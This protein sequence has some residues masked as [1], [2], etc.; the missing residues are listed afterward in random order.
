MG[1][2]L[3][4]SSRRRVAAC[5]TTGVRRRATREGEVGPTEERTFSKSALPRAGLCLPR[6]SRHWG[7]MNHKS[8]GP[9]RC[10]PGSSP[11]DRRPTQPFLPGPRGDGQRTGPRNAPFAGPVRW[12]GLP[13]GRVPGEDSAPCSR[14][15]PKEDSPPPTGLGLPLSPYPTLPSG[16]HPWELQEEDVNFDGGIGDLCHAARRNLVGDVCHLVVHRL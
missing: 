8:P 3:L 12:S 5:Q 14:D 9:L 1:L 15:S 16:T 2:A 6:S 10:P 4:A 13:P 11:L 7:R